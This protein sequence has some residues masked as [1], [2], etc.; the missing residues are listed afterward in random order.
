[1]LLDVYAP[2]I[3]LAARRSVP[4]PNSSCAPIWLR[5]GYAT[6][7]SARATATVGDDGGTTHAGRMLRSAAAPKARRLSTC[8]L[9]RPINTSANSCFA[10]VLYRSP[11]SSRKESS[12]ERVYR[13]PATRRAASTSGRT[14]SSSDDRFSGTSG[15][16]PSN[17]WET[18][19]GLEVHVQLRTKRKLFSNGR[20]PLALS[21]DAVKQ[22]GIDAG[23]QTPRWGPDGDGKGVALLDTAMPGTLPV[24]ATRGKAEAEVVLRTTDCSSGCQGR[25]WSVQSCGR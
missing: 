2:A 25:A 9:Q 19:I 17:D 13:H 1:M 10:P 24:S 8:S 22:S 15:R 16:F 6:T 5:T 23:R 14:E 18:V 21:E 7:A 11:L 20:G 12:L 4:A 3:M